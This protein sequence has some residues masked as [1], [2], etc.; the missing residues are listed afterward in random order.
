[1]T[2]AV[3]KRPSGS[4]RPSRAE[5]DSHVND[6]RLAL[7]RADALADALVRYYDE[8]RVSGVDPD[9]AERRVSHL[10]DMAAKPRSRRSRS[11]TAR[12]TPSS[13]A[14]Q[15]RTGGTRDPPRRRQAR[16]ASTRGSVAMLTRNETALR[17]FRARLLGWTTDREV[18]VEHA[19]RSIELAI[20]QSS[21]LVVLGEFDL[22]PI[23]YA[24]HRRMLGA[25]A[26]FVLSDRRR[27]S[28]PASVRAAMN[29][30]SGVAALEAARGGSLCVRFQRLPCDFS[31]VVV[32]LRS[33]EDTRLILVGDGR[34][35]THPFLVLPAPIR[36]PSL[37]VR[38][39]ELARIID[40]FAADA[41]AELSAREIGAREASFTEAST[42]ATGDLSSTSPPISPKDDASSWYPS[43]TC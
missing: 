36:I 39:K 13:A 12:G 34:Y 20:D 27:G 14:S 2:K 37:R 40:E 1:M 28:T 30:G 26:P 31:S 29:Q 11:S 35:D 4:S 25:D 32:Q 5:F 42:C 33:T 22:V 19:V 6:L 15:T 24:L 41:I 21:A 17:S 38:T 3:T 8:R 7:G 43:R 10:I 16:P 23:A 18:V 9:V